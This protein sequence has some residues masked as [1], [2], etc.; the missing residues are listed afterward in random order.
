MDTDTRTDRPD[1]EDLVSR[2]RRHPAL[3]SA[4]GHPLLH[5]ANMSNRLI[6]CPETSVCAWDRV[7]LAI[8]GRSPASCTL[9]I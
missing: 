3:K 2:R 9:S 6:V 8:D 1:V 4:T 5:F 7:A